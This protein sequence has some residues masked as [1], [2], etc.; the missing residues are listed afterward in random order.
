MKKE[1]FQISISGLGIIF[2]SPQSVKHIEE[3]E[4]YLEEH[5]YDPKDVIK[6]IY[7]GSIVG[8]ATGTPGDFNLNIY[9]NIQPDIESLDP[10][11]ALKLCLKVTDNSVYF[12]DL[13]VLLRW[14]KESKA[15]IKLDIEN[16]NYEVIVCSWLPESGIRGEN[17]QI[18]FYFNKTEN[19]PKL[20]YE[21]VPALLSE[22]E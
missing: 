1:Q 2:Y 7:E 6:H 14:E 16:G 22:S 8:I 13:Y 11:Y 3:G 4:N 19:L 18:D 5:Y 15:D 10:D 21:G 9:Q 20:H 12:R 17:Q